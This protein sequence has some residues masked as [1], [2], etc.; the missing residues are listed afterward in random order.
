MIFAVSKMYSSFEVEAIIRSSRNEV[1]TDKYY[2]S[3]A[4][5]REK[6]ISGAMPSAKEGAL[7]EESTG[8]LG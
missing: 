1:V 4:V 5:R 6:D 2:F 8:A 7:I 3:V